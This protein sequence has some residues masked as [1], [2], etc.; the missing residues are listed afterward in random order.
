MMWLVSWRDHSVPTGCSDAQLIFAC[1]SRARAPSRELILAENGAGL[2]DHARQG[3]THPCEA[4]TV[5]VC[6]PG[7][8]KPDNASTVAGIMGHFELNVTSRIGILYDNIPLTGR[9]AGRARATEHWRG[10]IRAD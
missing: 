3:A 7:V 5:M 8:R 10:G 2:S 4:M 1:W 6:L 9:T